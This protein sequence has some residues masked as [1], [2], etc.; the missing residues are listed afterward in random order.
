MSMYRQLWLAIIVSTLI[1]LIGSLLA[2]TIAARTYL[3]DQLSLKNA[4][5]ATALALTL[6]QQ[7]PDEILVELAVSALFD[8]G[9]YASIE[10][11]DPQ[12]APIISRRADTAET[13]APAWF[14]DLLPIEAAPG[15]AQLSGGWIQFGT[16]ILQSTSQFAYEALWSSVLRM[17]GA[18]LLA[19]LAGGMLGSLILNRLKSPLDAVVNQAQAITEKQFV[20]IKV[21][22]VPELRKLSEAMNGMAEKLREIFDEHA[23]K[24]EKVRADANTDSLT[25]LPNRGNFI[26]ELRSMLEEENSEG[27]SVIIL[28]IS[29]LAELNLKLGRATTDGLIIKLGETLEKV[30]ARQLNSLSA[31][32]NG[33]DFAILMPVTADPEPL[34]SDLLRAVNQDLHAYGASYSSASVSAGTF[35]VGTEVSTVL[36]RLDAALA[37]SQ[38]RADNRVE[39]VSAVHVEL[40]VS[41]DDWLSK[42]NAALDLHFVKL[43]MFPVVN[44]QG[45]VLHMEANLRIKPPTSEDWL[46]A[47][48]FFPMAERLGVSGRLDIEAMKHALEYLIHDKSTND[49]AINLSGASLGRSEFLSELEKIAEGYKDCLPRLWIEV[50]EEGAMN[51]FQE[52]RHLVQLMKGYGCKVG[53]EHFGRQLSQI[54]RLHGLGVHYLKVDPRFIHNLDQNLGNLTFLHGLARIAHDIGAMVIAEGVSRFLE[55][56]ALESLGFDGV[57][58]HAIVVPDTSV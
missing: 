42:I 32:L 10:V 48:Q 27:C 41:A 20:S 37:A 58:G 7:Q 49:V 17:L 39:M 16:V 36:A 50:S 43:A 18:A 34:A 4:D 51:Y 29:E 5:N 14:M 15:E 8:S 45:K 52:F 33:S 19:G 13:G 24:L 44:M 3:E 47:G 9:H 40:P 23:R 11:V 57:T 54:G 1:A 30:A 28:H 12:G 6:S 2:S 31:R 53:I 55:V 22:A 56:Q 38:A 35:K 25:M 21:P 46:V 26:G